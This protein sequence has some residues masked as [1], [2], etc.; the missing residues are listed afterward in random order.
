MALG[1]VCRT[2]SSLR[3]QAMSLKISAQ[4]NFEPRF[5]KVVLRAT[6]KTA[7][8]RCIMNSRNGGGR[9]S[10]RLFRHHSSHVSSLAAKKRGRIEDN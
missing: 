9:L 8:A 4:N 2:V 10:S 5:V 7:Q 6:Y 3:V 1:K